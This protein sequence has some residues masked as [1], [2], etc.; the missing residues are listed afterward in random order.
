M[1]L[2]IIPGSLTLSP[3]STGQLRAFATLT[4]NRVIEVTSQSQLAV[5]SV[6]AGDVSVSNGLV[7]SDDTLGTEQ[8]TIT[9]VDDNA[10][11]ATVDVTVAI[12]E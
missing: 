1:S 11:D 4:D 2:E 5:W 3:N 9:A 6:S 8:V 10:I 7:S 12:A